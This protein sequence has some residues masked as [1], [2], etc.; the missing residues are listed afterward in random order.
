MYFEQVFSSLT[1]PIIYIGIPQVKQA[2]TQAWLISSN[3]QENCVRGYKLSLLLAFHQD[4]QSCWSDT[5]EVWHMYRFP[6][7]SPRGATL[8]WQPQQE[9]VRLSKLY[10]VGFGIIYEVV[11]L[12]CPDDH[13]DV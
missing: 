7:Q 9:D 11:Y 12:F 6:S 5:K 1:S 10:K 8:L 13:F 4:F 3:G 2:P